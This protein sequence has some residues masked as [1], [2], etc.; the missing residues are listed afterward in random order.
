MNKWGPD[1]HRVARRSLMG[2]AF[3]GIVI[4]AVM[5]GPR[6]SVVADMAHGASGNENAVERTVDRIAAEKYGVTVLTHCAP[7]GGKRAGQASLIYP[8]IRLKP[9]ICNTLNGILADPAAVDPKNADN[10][11]AILDAAHELSHKDG[12][13]LHE[14]GNEGVTQC[15]GAQRSQEV[16]EGFGI[17]V[18]KAK[19]IGDLAA[20]A[21]AAPPNPEYTPPA[22]CVDGGKYDINV[23]SG[24]HFP[25]SAAAAFVSGN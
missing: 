14:E 11:L 5:F 23:P 19:I 9:S 18:E 8:T 7:L 25:R 3:A 22:G 1:R 20:I 13:G 12:A 16:A 4:G 6:P 17:P 15:L 24:P 21:A 2:T 10:A